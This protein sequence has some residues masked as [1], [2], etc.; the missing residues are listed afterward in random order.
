MDVVSE[1]IASSR[2]SVSWGV[3]VAIE[4]ADGIAQMLVGKDRRLFVTVWSLTRIEFT[5]L[6]TDFADHAKFLVLPQRSPCPISLFYL[7]S[8]L[9]RITEPEP[10]DPLVFS[11][12]FDLQL[13]VFSSNAGGIPSYF[14]I[15]T[16]SYLN[17]IPEGKRYLVRIYTGRQLNY[18]VPKKP[19]FGVEIN[20]EVSHAWIV[21][22]SSRQSVDLLQHSD[23]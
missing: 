21:R 22:V 16:S 18:S 17:T 4:V 7:L 2:P 8:Y 20:S 9:K 11:L 13:R 12:V 1:E 6:T 23:G 15:S 14:N 19:Y 10:P 3:V 5:Q